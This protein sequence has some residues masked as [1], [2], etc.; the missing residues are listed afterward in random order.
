MQIRLIYFDFPFWRA[1]ASRIALTM[2]G[3]AF[4]DVRP[5]RAEF[6][7]MKSSGAL[8][9]GQLPV[10]DVDGERIAQSVA[11]A[12]FCGKVSGLYPAS[13]LVAAARVD[14]LLDTAT[15]VTALFASSMREKDPQKKME[16]RRRI[17]EGSLAK[18][19]G[20]LEARLGERDYFVEDRITIADLVIWRLLGW[21]NGG[22][23]DGIP[24]GILADYAGLQAHSDR[25]GREPAVAQCM[26][27][28][29]Q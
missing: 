24:E 17:A 20:F 8:P 28:Y 10:L 1:E 15:Q 27:R 5:N 23:I 6:I 22:I 26:A 29:A 9:Y 18:T 11:I 7:E 14:E 19:L 21:V 16:M 12:R 2:G 13:D 3:V 4:E 25:V